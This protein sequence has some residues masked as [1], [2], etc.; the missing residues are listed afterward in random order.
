[1]LVFFYSL[2]H[3][4]IFHCFALCG[5]FFWGPEKLCFVFSFVA[6]SVFILCIDII[7]FLITFN[8]V[9]NRAFPDLWD[10]DSIY[11]RPT[12]EDEIISA[13]IILFTALCFF[14]CSLLACFFSTFEGSLPTSHPL[15]LRM[16]SMYCDLLY[17]PVWL[18]LELKNGLKL[19][20][21]DFQYYTVSTESLVWEIS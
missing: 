6:N 7:V 15:L 18:P 21:L 9:F 19:L 3:I 1:M 16:Y 17:S 11:W 4:L 8:N 20:F 14:E 2:V 13:D 5:F 10:S 12:I